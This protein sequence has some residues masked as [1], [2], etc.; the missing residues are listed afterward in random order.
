MQLRLPHGLARGDGC[1][2]G[3]GPRA[4]HRA[5]GVGGRE[6]AGL[7][8]QGALHPTGGAHVVCG[9]VPEFRRSSGSKHF[10]IL[11]KEGFTP[12]IVLCDDCP[13][14][15]SDH[16]S[17]ETFRMSPPA[18]PSTMGILTVRNSQEL[19]KRGVI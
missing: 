6:R 3:P 7:G 10:G 13:P 14:P 11:A 12:D 17:A 8:Q 5:G 1:A 18:Q 9:C 15:S 4:P 19:D 2:A 16:A